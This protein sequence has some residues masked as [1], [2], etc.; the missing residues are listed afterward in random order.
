MTLSYVPCSIVAE[1]DALIERQLVEDLHQCLDLGVEL[2]E[3]LR[4]VVDLHKVLLHALERRRIGRHDDALRLLHHEHALELLDRAR[5]IGGRQRKRLALLGQRRQHEAHLVFERGVEQLVGLVQHEQ[6]HRRHDEGAFV[7]QSRDSTRRTDR[8][9]AAALQLELIACDRQATDEARHTQSS[10]ELADAAEHLVALQRN[11]A[12]RRENQALWLASRDGCRRRRA[13]GA[14]VLAG[15]GFVGRH[16][17]VLERN[18]AEDT[19]LAGAALGLRD[20][21]DAQATERNGAQLYRRGPHEAHTVQPLQHRARQHHALK[22]H[23]VLAVAIVAN[24][25]LRCEYISCAFT[26]TCDRMSHV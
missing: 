21:V 13:S 22:V 14:G 5:R 7:H 12:S 11:L 2:L 6:P 1:H 20:D 8:D 24:A 25:S 23:L 18:D 17:E 16:I 26:R 9:V 10:H 15:A 3:R 19:G 4:A